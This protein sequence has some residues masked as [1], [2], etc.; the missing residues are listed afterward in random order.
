MPLRAT[1]TREVGVYRPNRNSRRQYPFPH[2]HAGWSFCVHP[3]DDETIMDID[4]LI[5]SAVKSFQGAFPDGQCPRFEIYVNRERGRL[6]VRCTRLAS[7]GDSPVEDIPEFR[8]N[9]TTR[10]LPYHRV[11]PGECFDVKVPVDCPG[12][13]LVGRV[14]ANIQRAH[15]QAIFRLVRIIAVNRKECIRVYRYV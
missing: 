14:R 8:A 1:I 9:W 6:V 5:R 3:D 2:M 4:R 15:P 12:D 10:P 11:K 7:I 13:L